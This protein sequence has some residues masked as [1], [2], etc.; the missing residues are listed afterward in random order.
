MSFLDTF[1][2]F[3]DGT[4]LKNPVDAVATA[5]SALTAQVT[6][7]E[8]ATV[9]ASITTLVTNTQ[10]ALGTMVASLRTQLPV[11]TAADGIEK[12]LGI[13]VIQPNGASKTFN[14]TFA[15]FTDS[16]TQLG[17]IQSTLTPSFIDLLN[18]ADP[19]AISDLTDITNSCST[20]LT[21]SFTNSSTASADGVETVQADSYA[22]YVTG[23]NPS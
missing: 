10:T 4:A 8:A 6:A 12:Q 13:A 9:I 2:A 23:N 21:T 3:K 7:P 16:T 14:D 1:N 17:I 20:A 11:L 18:A 22:K 15:P 5:I 19:T